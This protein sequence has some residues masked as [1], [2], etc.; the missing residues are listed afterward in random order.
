[1][2]FVMVYS[3][4]TFKNDNV[5]EIMKWFYEEDTFCEAEVYK[6]LDEAIETK[7]SNYRSDE[8]NPNLIY[9]EL[10]FVE[11]ETKT[12]P[13]HKIREIIEEKLKEKG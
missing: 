13:S 2:K 6:T 9:K 4:D 1:M 7:I 10:T 3:T 8:E 5:F 12:I 11:L